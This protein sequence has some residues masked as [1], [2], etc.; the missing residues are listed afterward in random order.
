MP[1]ILPELTESG[2]I[3]EYREGTVRKA[4]T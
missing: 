1:L 4:T 3:F 2:A